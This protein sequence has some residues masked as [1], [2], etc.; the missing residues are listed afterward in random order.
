MREGSLASAAQFRSTTL[1]S[2]LV[3]AAVPSASS[4]KLRPGKVQGTATRDI[5][6]THSP[7][8]RRGGVSKRPRSAVIC[9]GT[10]NR[11]PR[12]V[13]TH[14]V[15]N[16]ATARPKK[17]F[18]KQHAGGTRHRTEIEITL[19]EVRGCHTKDHTQ[20]KRGPLSLGL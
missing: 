19:K 18:G 11:R 17:A 5:W 13:G 2:P 16:R 4:K 14:A 10:T 6:A 20:A 15:E 7:C 9:R 1:P 8:P 3:L 12:D